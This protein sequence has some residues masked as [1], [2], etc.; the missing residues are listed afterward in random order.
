[1]PPI[2]TSKI[3]GSRNLS[4]IEVTLRRSG[5]AAHRDDA[6]AH[7]ARRRRRFAV[8][9]FPAD[10]RLWL[11]LQADPSRPAG[12]DGRYALR[13]CRLVSIGSQRF[14]NPDPA[15]SSIPSFLSS[16][17]ATSVSLPLGAGETEREDLRIR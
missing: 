16:V 11:P 9:I 15:G 7:R 17:L 14:S 3:D 8:V 12:P 4:G 13:A 5:Q 2:I 1:M 6:L 10:R